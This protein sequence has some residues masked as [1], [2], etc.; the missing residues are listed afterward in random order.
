MPRA[1]SFS[2]ASIAARTSRVTAV[3]ITWLE[4]AVRIAE[5]SA[6]MF[7]ETKRNG[8]R[9]ERRCELECITSFTGPPL[10]D[11]IQTSKSVKHVAFAFVTRARQALSASRRHIFSRRRENQECSDRLIGSFEILIDSFEAL[12]DSFEALIDSFEVRVVRFASACGPSR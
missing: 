12:I 8:R 10:D 5:E 9:P 6:D 1:D 3:W 4:T 2:H 7:D 11:K